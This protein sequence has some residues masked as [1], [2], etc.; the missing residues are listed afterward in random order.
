[1][2]YIANKEVRLMLFQI[3]QIGATPNTIP[4]G[5]QRFLAKKG[6]ASSNEL[7]HR[8]QMSSPK[9]SYRRCR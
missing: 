3:R 5:M 8:M 2:E 6:I 4:M 9:M 1:M 7:F